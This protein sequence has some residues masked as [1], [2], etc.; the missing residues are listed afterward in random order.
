MNVSDYAEDRG[1]RTPAAQSD[2]AGTLAPA[3][4]GC[5]AAAKQAQR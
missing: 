3:C 5:K 2:W 1:R 4:T